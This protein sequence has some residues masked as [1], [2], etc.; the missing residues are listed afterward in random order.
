MSRKVIEEIDKFEIKIKNIRGLIIDIIEH[1]YDK[2]IN[3]LNIGKGL[4][5]WR[6][7]K[8]EIKLEKITLSKTI[9]DT[10]KKSVISEKCLH[11]ISRHRRYCA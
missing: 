2:L 8:T 6:I 4:E 10:I 1:D 7:K 3:H 9:A 11:H 5:I